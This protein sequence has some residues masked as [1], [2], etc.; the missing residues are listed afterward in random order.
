MSSYGEIKWHITLDDETKTVISRIMRSRHEPDYRKKYAMILLELDESQRR[1]IPSIREVAAKTG[2]PPHFISR[3]RRICAVNGALA[4]L[5][6]KCYKKKRGP[7][8]NVFKVSLKDLEARILQIH[9]SPPP[10]DKKR[11]SY[12]D[13]ADELMNEG[14]AEFISR[15]RVRKIL[16]N[17]SS[18]LD[19]SNRKWRVI[20]DRHAKDRVAEVMGLK[21]ESDS[22]KKYARVLLELDESG[23]RVP[24]PV[25]VIV[26]ITGVSA[27]V[28]SRLCRKY[29][30]GG[31]D[32][33]L[34]ISEWKR[35]K[36]KANKVDP[37]VVED[38]ILR[39]YNSPPPEG[40]SRWSNQ[41]IADK[42][43]DDKVLDL[44]SRER[45]RR[46]LDREYPDRSKP[47]SA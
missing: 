12:Q 33:V 8:K 11:W 23:G 21:W 38:Y 28:I 13:I 43:L 36:R 1:V 4:A 18:G 17:I 34:K 37:K 9:Q 29:E 2:F 44:I 32:G 45:V 20:L 41:A 14:T 40:K 30:M 31:I 39:V 42:L 47:G 24:T 15:E 25:K 5:N 19:T 10:S 26:Q 46:V 27:A 22:K 35:P 7:R 16:Q 3:V 6:I